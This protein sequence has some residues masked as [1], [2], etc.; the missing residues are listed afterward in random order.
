MVPDEPFGWIHLAYALNELKRTREAWNVLLSIAD[1]FPDQD[2]IPYNL[3]C[4]AAQL[5]R[6]K[7]AKQW[8]ELAIEMADSK[9]V[10]QVALDDPDLE[11][12]R[13]EIGEL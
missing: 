8:L 6:L 4:Y 11:P 12:L 9:E 7:E 13:K 10:K 3:A 2:V 1:K 5:G